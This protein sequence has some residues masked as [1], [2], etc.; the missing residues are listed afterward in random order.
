MNAGVAERHAKHGS[1]LVGAVNLT[2]R[3]ARAYLRKPL[4]GVAHFV[5]AIK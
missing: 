3:N 2:V 1:M 4:H 5:E